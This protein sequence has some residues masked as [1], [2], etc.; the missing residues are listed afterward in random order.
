[1]QARDGND[2]FCRIDL[3]F[4][5]SSMPVKLLPK[6]RGTI[7]EGFLSTWRKLRREETPKKGGTDSSTKGVARMAAK[8]TG[9]ENS[10]ADW[11]ERGWEAD[12]RDGRDE[13]TWKEIRS[14]GEREVESLAWS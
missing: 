13:P 14:R 2:I 11:G 9:K 5:V 10:D 1:V 8:K 4:L 7:R 6:Q 3:V 12:K